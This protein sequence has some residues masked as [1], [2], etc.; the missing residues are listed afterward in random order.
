MP[1]GTK[2][3][4][5]MASEFEKWGN[6]YYKAELGYDKRVYENEPIN[7]AYIIGMLI[8]VWIF[9]GLHWWACFEFGIYDSDGFM[10][11]SIIIFIVTLIFSIFGIFGAWMLMSGKASNKIKRKHAFLTSQI[12]ELKKKRDDEAEKKKQEEEYKKKVEMDAAAAQN[13][14]LIA[15]EARI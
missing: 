2:G 11:Y 10:I 3:D 4:A 5:T 13:A 1:G 7:Y 12:E 14:K 6:R 9:N 8:L 15:P